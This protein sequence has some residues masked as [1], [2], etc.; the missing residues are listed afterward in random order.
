MRDALRGAAIIGDVRGKG[1]GAVQTIAAVLGSFRVSAHEWQSPTHLAERL[2]PPSP[3]LRPAHV[4]LPRDPGG[5]AACPG[6]SWS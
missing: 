4:P 3:G 6:A 1:L 2:E 5:A